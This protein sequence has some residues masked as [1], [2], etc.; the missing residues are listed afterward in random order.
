MALHRDIFWVGRQWA[1]TGFGLQAVDQ[2]LKG[3]IDITIAKLW[4]DDLIGRRR[5][6]AGLNVQDFEKALAI[7]RERFPQRA[8]SATVPS[9]PVPSAAPDASLAATPQ[10]PLTLR[11]EGSLARFTPQWRVRR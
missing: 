2:R 6:M 9:D 5:A 1:V 10:P 3:V 11:T 7:G 8:V 4:D